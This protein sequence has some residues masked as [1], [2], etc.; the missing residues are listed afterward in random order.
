MAEFKT[1]F[2]S[3]SSDIDRWMELYGTPDTLSGGT[4]VLRGLRKAEE[5]V[6]N[7]YFEHEVWDALVNHFVDETTATNWSTWPW[8]LRLKE[9]LVERKDVRRLK[10]C[11]GTMIARHKIGFWELHSFCRKGRIAGS[12]AARFY[13]GAES[14]AH[15]LRTKKELLEALEDARRT[16]LDLGDTAYAVKLGEDYT[17]IEQEKRGKKLPKPVDRTIDENCFWELIEAAK[18]NTKSS[19]EQTEMLLGSL[20]TFKAAE[21][22]RFRLILDAKLDALLHWDVWALAYLV[23]G[24]CSDDAF[25]Y[26]RSWLILQGRQVVA[27]AMA[28]I[29]EL[30]R[31]PSRHLGVEGL[32]SIPELAYENRSGKPLRRGKRKPA[33]VKGKQW[34]ES[35]LPS[36][37]PILYKMYF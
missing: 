12:A 6:F 33:Q 31:L 36:R 23:M 25:E 5:F 32:L 30:E 3:I 21:I 28:D 27:T 15:L 26:F 11:W 37:Y 8:L 14:E 19:S 2:Q 13:Q 24:G 10:R 20:E 16:M 4:P 34:E 7:L 22:N 18:E 1:N 9:T 35:D 17:L 29:Q